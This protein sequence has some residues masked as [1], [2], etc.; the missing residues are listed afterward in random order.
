MGSF[1]SSITNSVKSSITGFLGGASTPNLIYPTNSLLNSYN[2]NEN[3]LFTVY[4]TAFDPPQF[5]VKSKKLSQIKP[6]IELFNAQLLY[7][8]TAFSINH[9]HKWGEGT[10]NSALKTV[11][12]IPQL[13]QKAQALVNL[14]KDSKDGEPAGPSSI[15]T[16]YNKFNT[17]DVADVYQG[18]GKQTFDITFYAV[19]HKDPINEV[20]LPCLVFTYLSYPRQTE[21]PP[22]WLLALDAAT[23]A[24]LSENNDQVGGGKVGANGEITEGLKKIVDKFADESFKKGTEGVFRSRI[25]KVPPSW[26]VKTSNGLLDM[27]NAHISNITTTYYGPWLKPPSE[28]QTSLL[29]NIITG[30]GAIAG[31]GLPLAEVFPGADAIT[32]GVTGLLEGIFGGGKKAG[33]VELKGMPSYAE[34]KVTFES[35]FQQTFAEEWIKPYSSIAAGGKLNVRGG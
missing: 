15:A 28:E 17:V 3:N 24:T 8:D 35:N 5:G 14:F 11:G 18:S 32:G 16:E 23:Q 33:E 7:S 20:V 22:E 13:A 2:L 12:G 25:G 10:M 9:T 1:L 4:V 26:T 21:V 30:A 31:G 19:A 29:Q 34:I 27:A 6:P